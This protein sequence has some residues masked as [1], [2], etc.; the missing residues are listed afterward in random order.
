M[1]EISKIHSSMFETLWPIVGDFKSGGQIDILLSD[2]IWHYG[3]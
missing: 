1:K 2:T 3:S